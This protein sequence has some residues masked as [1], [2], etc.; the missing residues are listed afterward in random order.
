MN[1]LKT[2]LRDRIYVSGLI[3]NGLSL[4][5]FC[6]P[7][8][9]TVKEQGSFSCF[10]PCFFITWAYFIF[11]L[12]QRKKMQEEN[13]VHYTLLFL[14]LFLT[15]AYALNR[16]MPVFE[17]S[18][19][20]FSVLLVSSCVNY[21][22]FAYADALP[23]WTVHL[24][25]FISGVSWIAFFYLALYLFPVYLYSIVGAL[26][27]GFSLHAFVPVLF[28][29]YTFKLLNR[30]T[31]ADQK[32]WWSF[33]GGLAAAIGVIAVYAVMW[34]NTKKEIDQTWRNSLRNED[35]LPAW[36]TAAQKMPDNYFSQKILR[37]NLVYSTSE[38]L[39][40]SFFWGTSANKLDE[41][42]KHDPLVTMA[43]ALVGDLQMSD[44]DKIS[45]LKSKFTFRH[46]AQDRLW[47]GNHLFTEDVST[48]VRFWPACNITYTEKTITVTNANDRKWGRQEEAIYTFYMPEGAVVTSLSLWI[49]GKEEKSILTTKALAD[50]A[51]KSIVGV[52][53]RD[54]SVVHWQEGNSVSVRVFPV[55]AGESR[56]FKIG[57]TAPLARVNGKLKYENIYFNGP[58][59][60][61]AKENIL[62]DFE[63][64]V[65]DCE[66]PATFTSMSRQTYKRKGAYQPRWSML[67]NDPGLSGCSFSF[68]DNTY[69][70]MP[71]HQ[72]LSSARFEKIY[73]DINKA[74]SKDEFNQII[75][76]TKD[77]EVFVYDSG[78][79]KL[80]D[81]NKEEIWDKLH[82]MRFSL[83]PLFEIKDAGQALLVTKNTSLSPSIDDIGGSGFMEKTKAF[84]TGDEK[85]S[86]FDLGEDLSPY[87]KSFKEFRVFQY[88]RGN[89]NELQGLLKN[90]Q[91]PDDVENDD[92]VII[93][94]SD[95]VIQKTKG[96]NPSAG[97][98]H[99]MR[100]FTYNHIMQKLGRG[101][102]TGRAG[103]SDLV[104]EARKA[105]VVTPISS[106]VV[107]ETQKDYDRFGIKDKD[108]SLENA[109]LQSK[110]AVPE[111]HEWA[112][113]ITILLL[114]TY[115]IYKN[116]PRFS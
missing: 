67:I 20:W 61:D 77:R 93:H 72:K 80:S 87:L 55:L 97:P 98:D 45:I 82:A 113:I 19:N 44:D 32:Y 31:V 37:T 36:V 71:Y 107:L 11:L 5:F 34:N 28:T 38:N 51:Y 21:L 96:T 95:M 81:L 23:K 46:E 60:D 78:M 63:Q 73:L 75:D 43:V 110:G 29:I 48:E 114:L 70:T 54:P 4:F 52:E 14:T 25:S 15:S 103:E 62:I 89:V 99:M 74:W 47:S 2:R 35:E 92:R 16:D 58:A 49:N 9:G 104:E 100:L 116:K 90:N 65:N 105:Y 69:T 64:P 18:A 39:T 8:F 53:R 108:G 50:S 112:I 85:I 76:L 10:I 109:S 94:Q 59:F 86:L 84:L 30:A 41:V 66:L 83:F 106:L 40:G 27:L 33:L 42:K 1:I 17:D 115:L 88:D 111:P 57:I 7:F 79:M 22:A 56:K 101:Q 26:L 6:I 13:K 102:L 24:M 12:T 68:E 3:C 91:F